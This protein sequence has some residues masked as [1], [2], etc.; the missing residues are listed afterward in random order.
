MAESINQNTRFSSNLPLVLVSG[1]RAV[2]K[3][4]L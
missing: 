4:V 3:V 2:M 1:Q